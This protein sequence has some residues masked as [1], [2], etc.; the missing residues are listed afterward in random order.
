MIELVLRVIPT[1]I[2]VVIVD[3]AIR[4]GKFII[5]MCKT[6]NHRNTRSLNGR[7]I[8]VLNCEGRW[9]VISGIDP[10]NI[11]DR[12]VEMGMPEIRRLTRE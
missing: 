11:G 4:R 10:Q 1:G 6:G 9:S 8:A 3:D 2:A 5:R 7:R 12:R